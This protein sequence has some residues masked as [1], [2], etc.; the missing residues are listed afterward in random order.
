MFF[1]VKCAIPG[2]FHIFHLQKQG[3]M[4]SLLT[5]SGLFGA[6]LYCNYTDLISA[7]I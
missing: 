5:M 6:C 3:A 2:E 4:L 1:I 7:R